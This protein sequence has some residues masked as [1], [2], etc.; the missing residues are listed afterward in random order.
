[1]STVSAFIINYR[2]LC[3]LHFTLLVVIREFLSCLHKHQVPCAPRRILHLTSI[4][5]KI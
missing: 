2:H 4:Y 3:V 1:M 5:S